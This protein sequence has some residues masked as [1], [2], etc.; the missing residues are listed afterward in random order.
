MVFCDDEIMK[1][2]MH[3]FIIVICT[4]RGRVLAF[5][6]RAMLVDTCLINDYCTSCKVHKIAFRSC[7]A[8]SVNIRV[9][10]N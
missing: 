9:T 2:E 7:A 5:V 10:G 6:N 4:P 8:K 3:G 1:H